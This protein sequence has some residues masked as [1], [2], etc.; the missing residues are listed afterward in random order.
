MNKKLVN[1][2]NNYRRYM[3]HMGFLVEQE[4]EGG[5]ENIDD[6]NLEPTTADDAVADDSMTAEVGAD[7]IGGDLGADDMS[8]EEGDDMALGGD[9]END[10]VSD[11][12]EEPV[13][14]TEE[15]DV[16]DLVDG[17]KNL[18]GKFE[19]TEK[20]ISDTTT[21]VD[22]MFTKLDDLEAKIGELNQLYDAMNNL[23]AKIEASRPKKPEEKLELR[24][25]DSYPF[26]QKLTDYFRDKE[27]E[28]EL[29]G[30]NEYVLTSDEIEQGQTGDVAKSF[31]PPV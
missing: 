16:T 24:S 5:E 30:K 11:T 23:S 13:E 17:Q 8:G 18:E 26:N 6:L 1:E 7:E 31:T 20:K 2:I 27:P 14:D 10:P 28:M 9:T 19:D 25:L 12:E 29:S 3:K 4:D 15:V 22:G 21:K